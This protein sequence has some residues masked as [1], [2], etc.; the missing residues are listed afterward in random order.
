MNGTLFIIL[1]FYPKERERVAAGEWIA[2][3]WIEL[4]F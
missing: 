3:S 1:V 2:S 4:K